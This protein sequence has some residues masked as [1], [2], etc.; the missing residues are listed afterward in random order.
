MKSQLKIC[1]EI[2]W[3]AAAVA[4]LLM[5][6]SMCASTDAACYQAGETMFFMMFW[7]SFPAGLL[8]ALAA[9][10][11]LHHGTVQYPSDFITAWMV[12]AFGGFLQWFV[13]VPRFFQKQDLTILKLETSPTLPSPGAHESK[14]RSSPEPAPLL[15]AT[16]PDP[17]ATAQSKAVQVLNDRKKA[18]R[19]SIRSIAAFDR[20]GRTPLERVIDRL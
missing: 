16:I 13:I 3:L 10:L 9:L 20:R 6:T 14:S 7:L 15:K 11:F 1:L 4:I 12:L 5:G 2:A 18:R 19:K 8:F 17:P